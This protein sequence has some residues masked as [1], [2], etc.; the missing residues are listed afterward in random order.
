MVAVAAIQNPLVCVGDRNGQIG[1]TTSLGVL[2][3]TRS[4]QRSHLGTQLGIRNLKPLRG[5]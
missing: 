5:T 2:A 4:F 1:V 3:G